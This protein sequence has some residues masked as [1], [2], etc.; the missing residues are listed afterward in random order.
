MSTSK[1]S[2]ISRHYISAGDCTYGVPCIIHG[3]TY[4]GLIWLTRNHCKLR[5]PTVA[6]GTVVDHVGQLMKCILVNE[7]FSKGFLGLSNLST[8]YI[9]INAYKGI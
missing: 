1:L 7:H 2:C 6:L 8:Y 9:G 4:L 3:V 5:Q